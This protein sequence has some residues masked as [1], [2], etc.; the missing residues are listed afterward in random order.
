MKKYFLILSCIVFI[1]CSNIL[2]AQIK[3][4][5]YKIA[6]KFHIEGDGGWDYLIVDESTGRIFVSHGTVVNVVDEN[7]GKLLGTIPDTKGVHGIAIA[8][9][10]NKAF[11]SNG[12]DS[13]VTVIDLKSLALITKVRV[14]GQNPDAIIYDTFSHKVFVYNGRTAN[15]TI[16]VRF[17]LLIHQQIKSKRPGALHP[18]KSP[19]VLLL[20]MKITGCSLFAATNS[21][22]SWMRYQAK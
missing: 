9:D 11:I 17:L 6:N 21:W 2:K 15:A 18:V 7:D 14:T 12:R 19:A 13:S 5:K 1:I 16:K 8:A 10:L 20:I 3:P 4:S 22:L